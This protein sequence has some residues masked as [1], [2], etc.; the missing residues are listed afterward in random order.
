MQVC[1]A[2]V[3]DFM[4]VCEEIMIGT[5]SMYIY[6][7]FNIVTC[8]YLALFVELNEVMCSNSKRDK[9]VSM[10]SPW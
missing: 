1:W 7:N 8:L 2:G 3:R 10:L 5:E 6:I 9:T 4:V